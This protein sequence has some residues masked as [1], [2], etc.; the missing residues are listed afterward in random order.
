MNG[1]RTARKGALWEA[2]DRHYGRDDA[3]VLIWRGT[4]LEMNPTIPKD[5]IDREYEKDPASAAAEFGAEFRS[6]IESFISLDAVKACMSVERERLPDRRYRYYGF[7]DPSGGSNDAMTLAIAHKA[8]VTVV[9]DAIREVRPP[10]SPEAVVEEFAK[11]LRSYGARWFTAIA[12]AESGAE[13]YS[14]GTRSTM[15]PRTGRRAICIG[16]FCR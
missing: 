1:S 11:L 16:I 4:S 8:G 12:I 10:F 6:D 14:A 3:P 9:L 5:E 2:Y 13:R 15:S 7:C